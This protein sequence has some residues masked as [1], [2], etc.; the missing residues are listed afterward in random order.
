MDPL[1]F[2]LDT[3]LSVL[4]SCSARPVSGVFETTRLRCILAFIKTF[5]S[6]SLPSNIK[7]D[8]SIFTDIVALYIAAGPRLD[9]PAFVALLS[10]V[11]V[12]KYRQGVP[13][14]EGPL[15]QRP[16]KSPRPIAREDTAPTK[17]TGPDGH[18]QVERGSAHFATPYPEPSHVPTLLEH[19]DT[20]LSADSSFSA[21]TSSP[22]SAGPLEITCLVVYQQPLEVHDWS[23]VFVTWVCAL[24]VGRVFVVLSFCITAKGRPCLAGDVL[25]KKVEEPREVKT[26][27]WT[28]SEIE[29][30]ET[31]P[32][33][34]QFLPSTSL[35]PPQTSE[36]LQNDLEEN[37]KLKKVWSTRC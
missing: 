6:Y 20:V 28:L 34:Q 33:A 29:S 4:S 32:S 11:R 21:R 15:W 10:I 13:L 1:H 35:P 17:T 30:V 24:F 16:R 3:A 8:N 26:S 2:R 27:N 25:K 18:S 36:Y 23:T 5:Y 12:E 22:L 31:I 7:M 37:R 14:L 9:N 19:L